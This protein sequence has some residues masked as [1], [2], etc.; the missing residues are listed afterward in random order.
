MRMDL[1]PM[2]RSLEVEFRIS[3]VESLLHALTM[4]MIGPL[5]EG[6]DEWVYT[7]YAALPPS[8]KADMETVFA[9]L[10][11][12][13][14]FYAWAIDLPANEP[15]R[16]DFSEFVTKLEAFTEKD[17]Q[18]FL[19][20]GL[21]AQIRHNSREPI[22]KAPLLTLQDAPT[23]R[24]LLQRQEIVPYEEYLDPAVNLILNPAGLKD[25]FLSAVTGFWRQFYQAEHE[26][27][28]PLAAQSVEYHRRQNYR[29]DFSTIFTAVTGRV[30]PQ[31]LYE[32]LD[33]L[34]GI[35]KVIFLPSCYVGPYVTSY[36][37][38]ELR[39]LVL[40]FYNCRPTKTVTDEQSVALQNLFPSVKALADETRLQI[41][42]VL[43]GREL[44]AQQIVEHLEISQPAVSRHLQLMVAGGVLNVRKENSMKYYS[45]NK[46]VLSN[47]ADYLRRFQEK[48]V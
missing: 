41:L 6:V 47:L 48:S 17:F 8:L 9:F 32:D 5:Q 1:I 37:L 23:V 42:S 44:Y 20:S 18:H 26:R 45:I 25:R 46:E 15:S 21:D 39:P 30:L 4:V 11:I 13:S 40:L 3:L 36:E 16:R 28:L 35:S 2:R 10:Q 29:G 22:E 33:E 27:N 24:A 31:E 43:N 7:T 34:R 12:A 19:Q 38:S 14:P